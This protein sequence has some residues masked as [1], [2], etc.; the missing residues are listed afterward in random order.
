MVN[1]GKLYGFAVLRAIKSV[2]Y[3]QTVAENKLNPLR[4]HLSREARKRLKW[5]YVI[6]YECGGK[7]KRAASRIGVS[8]TWLSQVHGKWETAD[9][10]PRS[11]EPESR[12]PHDTSNRNRIGDDKKEKILEIR[13]KYPTWG[14]DKIAAKLRNKY[15]LKVGES[16]VNRYLRKNG[17]INVKI[18][19]KNKLS[20]EMK[21][22]EGAKKAKYRPPRE[23][24]DYRP[25]ALVEKDMKFIITRGQFTNQD[26]YRSRENFW[27]QQSFIDSFTR[28]RAIGLTK[29]SESKTAVV[30]KE[31]TTSRFPFEIAC[32]NTDS[33][34]ENLGD[35]EA[36]LEKKNIFHFRSRIGT[37]TDNPRVERSHLTDDLEFYNQ[38]N[39]YQTF[40]EQ[41]AALAEW[42][43][44]Y[45]FDRPHQALGQLTPMEFYE[46]WKKKP[47]E[48]YAIKDRYQKYLTKQKRRLANSRQMKKKEQIENLMQF[49]DTKLAKN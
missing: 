23:I 26:K 35:F 32:V 7:I 25:G 33:G 15:K 3:M 31:E 21:K 43:N 36:H 30:C 29:D 17:L 9:R 44:T 42:E 45:N 24:K 22:A 12:A 46:L 49:I 5:M 20:W 18:S 41:K 38:G 27:Y 28:L 10:D 47:E 37:P 13:E 40:E 6:H 4:Y 39:I 34:G 48:A 1:S 14:K 19:D 8:R 16:T 2:D 11:L